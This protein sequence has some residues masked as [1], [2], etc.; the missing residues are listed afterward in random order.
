MRRRDIELGEAGPGRSRGKQEGA[1]R[2]SIPSPDEEW[3]GAEFVVSLGDF[4]QKE[5]F[6]DEDPGAQER[7]MHRIIGSPHPFHG[8]G[9]DPH[10]PEL[11][12]D[13]FGRP[14]RTQGHVVGKELRRILPTLGVRGPEQD[15]DIPGGEG[16]ERLRAD[17]G[18][19]EGTSTTRQGPLKASRESWSVVAPPGTKWMGGSTWVPLWELKER[20]ETLYGLPSVMDFVRWTRTGGSPGKPAMRSWMGNEMSMVR[21]IASTHADGDRL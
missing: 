2:P 20:E 11:P 13:G 9:I 7:V 18:I 14:R 10:E 3:E 21:M 12:P 1:S 6:Q 5:P 19:P 8:E 4:P 15:P 17:L 16:P